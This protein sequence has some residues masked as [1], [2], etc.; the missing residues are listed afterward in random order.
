MKAVKLAE[1]HDGIKF[2]S[3]GHLLLRNVKQCRSLSRFEEA[4]KGVKVRGRCE[5]RG[6]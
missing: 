4:A 3:Q 2:L 1:D 6:H 5:Q